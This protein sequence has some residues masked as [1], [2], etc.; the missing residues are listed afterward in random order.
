MCAWRMCVCAQHDQCCMHLA[1]VCV[2]ARVCVLVRACICMCAHMRLHVWGH[3]RMHEMGACP[4]WHEINSLRRIAGYPQRHMH[5]CT[6]E[7]THGR[8]N[9]HTYVRIWTAGDGRTD[10]QTHE[11]GG[12]QW[13]VLAQTSDR[14][15]ARMSARACTR[16]HTG[17]HSASFATQGSGSRSKIS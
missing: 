17:T 15:H 7:S 5:A 11:S 3:V 9:E 4:R 12:Y 8:T 14:T 1:R 2:C 10:V 16:A 6:N 13:P